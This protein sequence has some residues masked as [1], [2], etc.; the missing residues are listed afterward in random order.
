M[1]SPKKVADP[2]GTHG[3]AQ[4]PFQNLLTLTHTFLSFLS[5]GPFENS[6][7]EAQFTYRK[8]YTFKM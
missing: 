7:M 4:L 8:L 3:W 2:T 5:K 1:Q 6:L